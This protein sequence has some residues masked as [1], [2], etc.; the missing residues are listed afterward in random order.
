[1]QRAALVTV[2]F[3]WSFSGPRAGQ[4]ERVPQ[5][6]VVSIQNINVSR[7]EIT[8]ILKLL[9]SNLVKS[10]RFLVLERENIDR[11]LQEQSLRGAGVVSEG[12]AVRLGRILD[13]EKIV[14]GSMMRSNG[15]YFLEI[16]LIDIQTSGIEKSEIV[17]FNSPDRFSEIVAGIVAKLCGGLDGPREKD[18]AGFPKGMISATETQPLP[19]RAL[20]RQHGL[21]TWDFQRYTG[22]GLS[23]DQWTIDQ[24]RSV[25]VSALLGAL[26][27]ASGLYYSRNYGAGAF[28]SLAELLGLAGITRSM[29]KGGEQKENVLVFAGILGAASVGDVIASALAARS[30]NR[31]LQRLRGKPVV[32][33]GLVPSGTIATNL[34]VH[35]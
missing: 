17:Q 13:V 27:L 15:D 35:F 6:A 4:A 3:L 26:P 1:M 29:W 16:R 18:T 14:I 34:L 30:Y 12:E 9:Q 22:S 8:M 31:N 28:V 7:L 32:K 25:P 10:N 21:S 11:I 2:I 20:F 19:A 33:L 24:K 23:L 5:V